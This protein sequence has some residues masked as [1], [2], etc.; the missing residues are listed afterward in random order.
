MAEP[1]SIVA[2]DTVEWTKSTDDYSPADG[3]TLHYRLRGPKS[4]DVSDANVVASG[5]EWEISIPATTTVLW[6]EG[7]YTLYGWVTKDADSFKVVE[8]KVAILPDFRTQANPLDNRSHVKRTLD[9]LEAAIEGI[10]AREESSYTITLGNGQTRTFSFVNRVEL[11]QIRNHYK[12]E[13]RQE[14][15][16]ER[17]AQGLGSGGKILVRFKRA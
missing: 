7:D 15:Q 16:A 5:S 3:W 13:Y 2:G 11:N 6:A 14:Q 1:T 8:T 12:E 17:I 10:S 9:A 4:I